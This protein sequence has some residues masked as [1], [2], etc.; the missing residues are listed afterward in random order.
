VT[1][2]AAQM[3]FINRTVCNLT[4]NRFPRTCLSSRA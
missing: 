1:T 2:I 4:R 3:R